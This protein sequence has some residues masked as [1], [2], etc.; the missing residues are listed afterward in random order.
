MFSRFRGADFFVVQPI[1]TKSMKHTLY[2]DPITHKFA[3]VRIP[4]D[5][6]EGDKLPIPPKVQWLDSRE[7][8]VATLRSL[9]DEDED[10][11]IP[12]P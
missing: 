5:H 4:P 6:I 9:L 2:E 11:T 10:A 7:E 12:H 1:A 3:L 8:A